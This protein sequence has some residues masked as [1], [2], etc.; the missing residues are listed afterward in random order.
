M[1]NKLVNCA[2]VI[3]TLNG[4]FPVQTGSAAALCARQLWPISSLGWF[5][6]FADLMAGILGCLF[7]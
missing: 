3:E 2:P 5:S 4:W 6:A 7:Y 1:P